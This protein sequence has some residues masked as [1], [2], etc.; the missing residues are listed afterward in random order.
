MNRITILNLVKNLTN[1]YSKKII[2]ITLNKI[3]DL[4]SETKN[5]FRSTG[6]S[7]EVM[8]TFYYFFGRENSFCTIGVLYVAS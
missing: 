6:M 3:A 7:T 8:S 1:V 4:N 5:S 2:K